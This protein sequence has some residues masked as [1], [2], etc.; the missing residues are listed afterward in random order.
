MDGT[1]DG[2]G[3]RGLIIVVMMVMLIMII[4]VIIL[5]LFCPAYL[6]ISRNPPP[7]QI[8][9]GLV[10]FGFQF[11]LAMTYADADHSVHDGDGDSDLL[12]KGPLLLTGTK[13][14]FGSS[15][16]ICN[17]VHLFQT[18]HLQD[19]KRKIKEEKQRKTGRGE[20]KDGRKV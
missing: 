1:R 16:L 5:T 18:K 7:P 14:H 2:G 13:N 4:S 12:Q 8:S 6:S 11:F 19:K 17:I 3:E 20:V 15:P 9:F 10:G